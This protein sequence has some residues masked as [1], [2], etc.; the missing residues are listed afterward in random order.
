MLYEV[1]TQIGKFH[2]ALAGLMD[3]LDNSSDR[4]SLIENYSDPFHFEIKNITSFRLKKVLQNENV[5]PTNENLLR[6]TLMML[7]ALDFLVNSQNSPFYSVRPEEIP[8]RITS[9][10]VCYTKLLRFLRA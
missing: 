9:Y 4:N 1:I 2:A 5:A 10:N 6:H 7:S 3:A 8:I